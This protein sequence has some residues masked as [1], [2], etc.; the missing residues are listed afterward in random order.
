MALQVFEISEPNSAKIIFVHSRLCHIKKFLVISGQAVRKTHAALPHDMSMKLFCGLKFLG[1]T[2][3]KRGRWKV[4]N[5][6]SC[7]TV[8]SSSKTEL[9]NLN[10]HF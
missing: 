9:H 10:L 8:T 6:R 3:E 5:A 4:M 1:K 7:K 2:S